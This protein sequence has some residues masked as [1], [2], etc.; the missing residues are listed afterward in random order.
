MRTNVI[1]VVVF[2]YPGPERPQAYR[3][4]NAAGELYAFDVKRFAT[5]PL[6]CY[7]GVTP[8]D[9]NSQVMLYEARI[10]PSA[11]LNGTYT[12]ELLDKP[13]PGARVLAMQMVTIVDTEYA[14]SAD[15]A[16]PPSLSEVTPVESGPQAAPISAVL[17]LRRARGI[18]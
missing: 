9:S 13:A 10:G 18:E 1:M 2:A 15:L 7:G 16:P 4:R 6:F 12:L 17:G 3:I 5:N 11:K 14:A 8:I